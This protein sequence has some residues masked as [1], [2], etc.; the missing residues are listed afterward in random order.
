MAI[1]DQKNKGNYQFQKKSGTTK[2]KDSYKRFFETAY[3]R[4]IQPHKHSLLFLAL[5]W[6]TVTYTKEPFEER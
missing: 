5:L 6:F 2:W 3:R 1:D 4:T